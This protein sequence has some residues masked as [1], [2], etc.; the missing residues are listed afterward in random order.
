MKYDLRMFDVPP[1]PVPDREYWF[2]LRELYSME[3]FGDLMAA[4][5]ERELGNDSYAGEVLGDA[6][7]AIHNV[8][9]LNFFEEDSQD[10]EKVL[11]IFIRVNSGGTTLSYSDLLLSIATAQ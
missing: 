2:P 10:V 9:S 7:Q 5:R 4:L 6:F 8:P 1:E 11:D 3:S